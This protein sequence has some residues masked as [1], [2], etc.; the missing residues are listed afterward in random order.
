MLT[1]RMT[2]CS[3][4][5]CCRIED[6]GIGREAA[7]EIRKQQDAPH[8]SLGTKITESRIGIVNALYGTDLK[9]TYTDLK[10][11]ENRPCGTLVE[12]QLPL[13]S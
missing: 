4:K 13:M 12:L 7:Q 1:I 6:N 3:Q 8:C 10:D 11:D 5:I 2:L 9:V